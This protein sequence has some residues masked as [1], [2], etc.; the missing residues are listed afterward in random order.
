VQVVV[1]I[2]PNLLGWCLCECQDR[3]TGDFCAFLDTSSKKNR[4]KR[5]ENAIFPQDEWYKM[6]HIAANQP[7]H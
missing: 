4:I 2:P 7:F 3:Q 5:G 6:A 1:A